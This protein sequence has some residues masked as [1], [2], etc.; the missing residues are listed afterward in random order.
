MN[1]TVEKEMLEDI[2]EKE[3][4]QEMEDVPVETI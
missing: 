2:L 3:A 1:E 4:T